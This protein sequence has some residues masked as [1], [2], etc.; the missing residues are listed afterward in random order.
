MSKC[1]IDSY[2]YSLRP[3]L[4]SKYVYDT[5][6]LSARLDLNFCAFALEVF[7]NLV[8]C[9]VFCFRQLKVQEYQTDEAQGTKQHE[10]VV[11]P[12]YR[13]EIQIKLGH[14][15]TQDE[16]RPRTSAGSKVF[17]PETRDNSHECVC[18]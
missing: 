12:R 14:Q 5:S 2:S 13:F 9:L 1:A 3:V 8:Q 11:E 6:E 10:R 15:E 16:V 18:V 17:T 4:T 7:R